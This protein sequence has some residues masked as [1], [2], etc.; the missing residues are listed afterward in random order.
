MSEDR[1]PDWKDIQQS[2][3]N[4]ATQ[5]YIK[6]LDSLFTPSGRSEEAEALI[7]RLRDAHGTPE[8]PEVCRALREEL[9]MPREVALLSI[10]LDSNDA[11]LVVDALETML[12][13][14]DAEEVEISKGVQSQIRVLSQDFNNAIAEVAEDILAKL[15]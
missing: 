5:S 8:L 9:G 4:P 10:F 14:L 7:K 12:L 13:M 3:A 15:A 2:G 1:K 11:E 6:E